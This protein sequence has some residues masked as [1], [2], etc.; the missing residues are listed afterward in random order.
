MRVVIFGATGMVT[1]EL[2]PEPLQD[3]WRKAIDGDIAG[4]SES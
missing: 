3:C 4:G 2:L 1:V